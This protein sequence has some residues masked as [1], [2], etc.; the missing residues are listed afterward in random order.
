MVVGEYEVIS[1]CDYCT[2]AEVKAQIPEGAPGEDVVLEALIPLMSRRIDRYKRVPISYYNNCGDYAVVTTHL[3]D[4]N[5]ETQLWIDRCT[6]IESVL[7]RRNSTGVYWVEGTDYY[8]W[9]WNTP[10]IARLDIRS[11]GGRS[12]WTAGQRNIEIAAKWGA[13]PDTPDAVKQACI[14][15]ISRMKARGQQMFRDT[16]AIAELAQLA[17]TAAI[18]PEVASILRTVPGR[19]IVG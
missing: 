8:T 15:L 5:G 4:G 7:V 13:F 9:P 10:W 3:F 19:L 12:S 1:P 11:Q 18:D 14:M 16:G 2:L 17:Y 6:E